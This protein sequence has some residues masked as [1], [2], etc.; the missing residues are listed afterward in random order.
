[1]IAPVS[2]LI[3]A[4]NSKAVSVILILAGLFAVAHVMQNQKTVTQNKF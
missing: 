2:M 4:G 3:G 1:M